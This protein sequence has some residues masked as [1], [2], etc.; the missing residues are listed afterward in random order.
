MSVKA[1]KGMVG[2]GDEHL[3][4]EGYRDEHS[5]LEKHS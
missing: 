1:R 4:S 5:G 2:V 3:G